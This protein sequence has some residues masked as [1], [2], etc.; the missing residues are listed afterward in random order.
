M[1]E[2]TVKLYKHISAGFL[3]VIVGLGIVIYLVTYIHQSS[4]SA[5]PVI[6]WTIENHLP[7]T[8]SLILLSGF[9][10][11]LSSTLIY[12]QI[13]KTKKESRQLLETLFLF[14]NSDEKEIIN[15]LMQNNGKVGQADIARLP[16]MNRVRAFRSLQ[17]MQEKNLVTIAAHG[18]IR[19][20]SLKEDILR[21]LSD[22]KS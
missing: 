7:I 2:H 15:Y 3:I 22:M 12:K 6:F 14:L 9:I 5:N 21:L 11:Y 17:R 4:T 19:K 18:K 13:M 16:N 8:V 1:D 20:V 10:G